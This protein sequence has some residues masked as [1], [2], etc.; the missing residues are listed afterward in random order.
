MLEV[1]HFTIFTDHKPIT[2]AFQQKR[3]DVHRANSTISTLSPSSRQT[4]D[5]FQDRTT[6]SPTP[7]LVLSPSLRPH[8][9]KHWPHHRTATTSSEHS[10]GQTP[11][12]GWRN[13]QSPAP[14]SPSTLT[15]LLG[16]LDRMFQL[17]YGSKCS[18]PS[19]ICHTQAPKQRQGWSH[20]TSYGRA[21]R[22]IAAPGHGLVSPASA[23]KSLDTW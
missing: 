4:S 16:D 2:S 1:H 3:I 18:S 8:H 9:T 6:L 10:W 22:R 12:C 7:Y 21:C 17:P 11:P 5:T 14:R 15:L 23:P 19:M 20:N 13:Y